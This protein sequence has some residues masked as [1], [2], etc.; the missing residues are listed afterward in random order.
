MEDI[1]IEL[2]LKE[3]QF[4]CCYNSFNESHFYGIFFRGTQYLFYM[5]PVFLKQGMACRSILQTICDK[6][7]HV[8]Q[9]LTTYDKRSIYH[10]LSQFF[11]SLIFSS[12]NNS[13]HLPMNL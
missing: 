5:A 3:Y 4:L 1:I 10:V 7:K 13:N 2:L 8:E 11:S 6:H 9:K 12:T